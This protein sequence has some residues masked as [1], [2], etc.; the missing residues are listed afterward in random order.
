MLDTETEARSIVVK[1]GSALLA[2]ADLLTPRFGFIQRLLEDVT[3]LRS[4]GYNVI[5]CS[6]G[7]VALG[8]RIVGETPESAGV[9]DKQAAAA[10]GMPLLL[11]AYKQVGHEYGFEI[12]QVLLTLGDFE[13]HRRFLNTRNTV[14]R[15]LEAGVVPIVNENDSITTEEIRVGDNDRLAAKVAQMI[16]ANDLIILTCV[17]GL[18][19]RNPDEPGAVLVEEVEDVSV[20]M[21]ATIGMS[22]LGSGGMTTKLK[23]ANMAQEAGCTTYIANGEADRPLSSVLNGERRCTKCLPHPNPLSGK[24]SWIANRLQMAGSLE[25]SG[26][27]AAALAGGKRSLMREDVVSMDGDFTRGDV[28]HLYDCDG[29]E[30][31][32]GLSDFTSEEIRVMISNP[33]TLADQ[34]LGYKTKG[35]IIRSNNLVL[36]DNRHLLWA[37]PEAMTPGG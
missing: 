1:I 20:Y 4:Q 3:R 2:N 23:A 27:V 25:I 15:L 13:H 31:A 8:L 14:H 11:N 17:D 9:S 29:V 22:A 24:D 35:E 33:D 10:C 12:A 19:D 30:L 37:A 26:K 28:L 36:L 6:S 16:G 32:R 34:L 7:A 5:L 21:E 18:Y